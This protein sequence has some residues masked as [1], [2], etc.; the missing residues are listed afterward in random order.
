MAARVASHQSSARCSL[1]SGRRRSCSRGARPSA[2]AFP[3]RSHATTFAAVLLQS[4]PSA[5]S[6]IRLLR[7]PHAVVHGPVVAMGRLPLVAS[8]WLM[9]WPVSGSK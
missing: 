1:W 4:I 5:R 7:R 3:L 9:A 2:A 6:P 8:W